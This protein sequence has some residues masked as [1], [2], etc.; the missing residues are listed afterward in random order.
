[1]LSTEDQLHSSFGPL[2][3]ISQLAKVLDRSPEGLRISLRSQGELAR[4]LL[5]SKLKLGRR[6]Y[7]RTAAV[8]NL[9]DNI[10]G[11]GHELG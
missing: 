9:I 7:F 3:T 5:P 4:Q 10:S 6:V 2:M 1:M 11:D 8:A